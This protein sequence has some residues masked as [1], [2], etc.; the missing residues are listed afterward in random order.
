MTHEI[1]TDKI[2]EVALALLFLSKH[3]DGGLPRAWKGIDWD[4]MNRLYEKGYILDPKNKEKSVSITK[5]GKEK[6]EELFIM[7]FS[8]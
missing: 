4:V 8:K 5:E 3:D 6:S 2:D 7:L 1:D